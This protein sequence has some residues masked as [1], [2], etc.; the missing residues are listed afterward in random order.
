MQHRVYAL[1]VSAALVGGLAFGAP[2]LAADPSAEANANTCAGCHGTNGS[3]VGPASPTIANVTKEYFVTVMK[4]Y[5]EGKRKATIMDR[6]AKGYSD[7]EIKAMAAYFDA[8]TFT[9]FPQQVDAAAAG[10]GKDLHKKYCE[11]CHEQEGRKS[12]GIGVLAGQ[13][14]MYLQHAIN[15]FFT[16]RR[17]ME[18]RK[19]QKMEQLKADQGEH[20]FALVAE[21][22]ASQK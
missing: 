2:A 3:S 10:K 5:K 22:Y 16:G 17:V 13:P 20:G 7:E 18:K 9:R 4:E 1:F 14:K 19:Q 8:K 21:Y 11:S 12:D 6:I 15:D